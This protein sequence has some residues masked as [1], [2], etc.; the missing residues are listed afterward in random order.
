MTT[1]LIAARNAHKV[2]EIRALLGEWLRYLTSPASRTRQLL[3]GNVTKK[4]VVSAGWLTSRPQVL[5]VPAYSC[6]RTTPTSMKKRFVTTARDEA[7][8]G[9]KTI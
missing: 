8:R 3:A 7:S 9:M 2:R 6:W 4:A 5:R 1:L